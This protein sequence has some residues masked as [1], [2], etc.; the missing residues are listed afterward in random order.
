MKVEVLKKKRV[1]EDKEN[2]PANHKINGRKQ[3]IK[4]E[5]YI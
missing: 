4:Y 5:G 1:L 2:F 3:G